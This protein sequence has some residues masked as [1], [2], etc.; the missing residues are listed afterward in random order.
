L[1]VLTRRRRP[2]HVHCLLRPLILFNLHY[3]CVTIHL[4][5][6]FP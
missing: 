6:L 4:L 1:L 2:H 3:L 5:E